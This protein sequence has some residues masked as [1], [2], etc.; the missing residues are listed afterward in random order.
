MENGRSLHSRGRLVGAI[1]MA[2]AAIISCSPAKNESSSTPS[3]A[4]GTLVAALCDGLASCCSTEKFT[5]DRAGCESSALT[6]LESRKP[7]SSTA[8]LDSAAVMACATEVRAAIGQCKPTP[9]AGACGRLYVGTVATNGSCI[10]AT[11][12]APV[13]GAEVYCATVCYA[14]RRGALGDACQATCGDLICNSDGDPP[15]AATACYLADGLGCVNGKCAAA[16]TA[17]Q[18]CANGICAKGAKCHG[19]TLVCVA[20]AA[21]GGD[22]SNGPCVAGA[23]C[24]SSV[25]AAQLPA[26]AECSAT[27]NNSCLSGS[28]SVFTNNAQTCAAGADTMRWNAVA[29][30]GN[31]S[32]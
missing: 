14:R 13:I 11:D 19:G 25:C 21:I 8:V 16:P 27:G 30:A 31:P 29:C 9:T 4:E 12:C 26:G 18:A 15:V 6:M 2:L 5:F 24:H 22:C 28:C 17:G 20:E 32:F 1:A 3:S 7:S 10:E 23:Y